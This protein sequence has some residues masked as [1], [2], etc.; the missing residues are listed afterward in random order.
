L[1][2]KWAV[3][4]F[5]NLEI[6][7][8]AYVLS[9]PH[10]EEVTFSAPGGKLRRDGFLVNLSANMKLCREAHHYSVL[11][12]HAGGRL[13][14]FYFQATD[15]EHLPLAWIDNLAGHRVSVDYDASGR[16]IHLR[17]E[18]ERRTVEITYRGDL[19]YAVYFLGKAGRKL[20]VQ[21]EYDPARRLIKAIDAMGYRKGYEY[22]RE[23]RLL[24]ETSPLG[25]RFVFQ[26]DRLGRCTRTAGA[27]GFMERKLQYLKIPRMTR[28]T[29][30]RGAVTQYFLNPAGQVIQ[31]VDPA[32]GVT[33]NTFDENGR[34][35]A[36]T[37]PDGSTESAEY[38][39]QGNRVTA[40]DSCGAK[41]AQVCDDLHVP[42]KLVDRNGNAWKLPNPREGSLI[43]LE[44]LPRRLWEY[45][46]DARSLVTQARSRGG[47][48]IDI[49]RDPN[50][51]WQEKWDESSLVRRTEYDELG[52]VR[53]VQDAEG[54]VSR[55][56]YD[57]LNRPLEVM[58]TA[59]G[60]ESY[61]WN[62]AG[63]MT[64]RVGPNNRRDTWRYDQYGHLVT[65]TD[66]LGG[67]VHFEYDNEGSLIAVTNRVGERLEYKRDIRGL[68]VEEK[69]FDGRIQRYRYDASGR[70]M[71][72]CLS[73]GRTIEQLFDRGGRLLRRQAS[74]GLVEEF[75]YDKEGRMVKAWNNHAVVE[76]KRDCFG[77]ILSETQNGRRVYFT[78]D[79]DGNRVSRT[80][81]FAALGCRLM[82]VYDRRGRLLEIRDERGTCQQFSRDNID[83]LVERR[84]S[85]GLVEHF[86][87][88]AHRRLHQQ[89]VRSRDARFAWEHIYDPI[90]NLA[91]LTD[92]R[93]GL[94]YFS[95]D[96]LNR[97]TNV[98]REQSMGMVVE[99]YDYDANNSMM[100]NHR[101]LR[102]LGAG[103]RVLQDG[104]RGIS[105][106]ED[107]AVTGIRAGRSAWALKHDVNGRLVQVIPVDGKA[108]HYQY[109]PFGRRTAKVIG[110]ERTEFLWEGWALAAEVRDN[111]V[112]NIFLSV[113]LRPVAQWRAGR[114]FTLISD[115]RG[116][117]SDVFDEFGEPRW[118]CS[119]D[120]YG[121]LIS[122]KGDVPNPFRLRGQYH[123]SETG[124]YYNFHR[125][126]DPR[127]SNYTA[128]DPIGISGGYNFYAYP[129]NPL[130]WHDPFG[131]NCP[132]HEDPPGEDEPPPAEDPAP[133]P[134]TGPAPI[135]DPPEETPPGTPAVSDP[136]YT[137]TSKSTPP[138][139]GDPGS[140]V[141]GG[142]QSRTYGP[143]GYPATDRDTGH[144]D[145]APP[146]NGDHSH[147]WGRPPD[148][149]PPIGGS[150]QPNPY[151]GN[152]RTPQPGDPPVPRGP[153]VPPP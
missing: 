136:E 56:D 11:H 17:Q 101:G 153:N 73:D 63:R 65:Q 38:D 79:T 41:T 16:P 105:Y 30:S 23:N 96:S 118:S 109:D 57:D 35:I 54:V 92:D 89:R 90:G 115:A 83:R 61:K 93:T 62:A 133:K 80:L 107:G 91:V 74:D 32:G 34:L 71:N 78:Y 4:Y 2:E 150:G 144:P 126:Y 132:E 67:K 64:Q 42:I 146:G 48:L 24:A 128:P 131:L 25:S 18:L 76:L 10:G 125:H 112:V 142:T 37:H 85:G 82:R 7:P 87:Y 52:Y 27:D 147:D 139:K 75:L 104:S 53:Q 47:W 72:I 116:A 70:R 106:G 44:D 114:R 152:G 130:R 5:M 43:G 120:A 60:T 122:E 113:E 86:T 68:I 121:N 58:H 13:N 149:G 28:V 77:R 148:G 22:D 137:D 40:T 59:S 134:E 100:A 36:V 97:L 6:R 51:S 129:R 127:L 31:V 88:D 95:Y 19:I 46:W 151:R 39:D 49:R 1:G 110:Q 21:Y 9:G 33:T 66:P 123:D 50:F 98:R 81:P 69:L 99:T 145:E 14:R 117:V 3:P 140:T 124:L 84:C 20:L 15:Q 141:R 45:S 138:F 135:A 119:L 102:H 108:I 94:A 12:W 8:E 111:V 26:Y 29:D 103:G 143:D 55:T